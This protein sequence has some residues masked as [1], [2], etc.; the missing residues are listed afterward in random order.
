[1]RFYTEYT[2]TFSKDILCL[3]KCNKCNKISLS[4]AKVFGQGR[5]STRYT[6]NSFVDAED[7]AQGEA[8]GNLENYIQEL[9]E[10]PNIDIIYSSH[11]QCRCSNCGKAPF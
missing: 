10:Q 1:M 5:Q 3:F 8:Q 6:R 9:K 4:T 7:Q 2:S 11:I